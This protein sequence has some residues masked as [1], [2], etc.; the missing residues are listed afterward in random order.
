MTD[1][2]ADFAKA[3]FDRAKDCTEVAPIDMLREAVRAIEA[4]EYAPVN[5]ILV[6]EQDNMIELMHS[7]PGCTNERIG[8][9]FRG[10][11]VMTR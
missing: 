2:V 10:M 4:G 7:G 1:N 5:L 9:L 6:G 11:G 3:R 8:M